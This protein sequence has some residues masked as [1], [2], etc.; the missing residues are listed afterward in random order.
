MNPPPRAHP[1]FPSGFIE[2]ARC[3]VPPGHV[4]RVQRQE[5]AA[6]VALDVR[7]LAGPQPSERGASSVGPKLLDPLALPGAEHQRP[8]LLDR[9]SRG[10]PLDVHPD[11]A[12][13]SDGDERQIP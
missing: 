3:G 6:A 9:A 2:E 5:E 10:H 11:F 1:P 4:D 13:A 8:H 12:A 7:L